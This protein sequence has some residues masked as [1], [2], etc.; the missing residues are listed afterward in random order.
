MKITITDENV[1]REIFYAYWLKERENNLTTNEITIKFRDL[2]N[3]QISE[4]DLFYLRS[5]I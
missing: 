1:L 3:N 5:L 2:L 4:T